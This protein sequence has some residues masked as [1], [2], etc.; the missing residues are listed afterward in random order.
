[1]PSKHHKANWITKER[2]L[3]I[4][5]RDNFSCLF[6]GSDLRRVDPFFITLDHLKCRAKHGAN[7]SFSDLVT[8]CRSCN[9]ARGSKEWYD[10]APGGAKP[11]IQKHRR[12]GMVRFVR[13][14]TALINGTA[15]GS[16]IAY[17]QKQ[18]RKT[19]KRK[20]VTVR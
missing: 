11:R 19:G 3:A 17:A 4:Y 10:Y 18:L 5:L 16:S 9:S 7:D 20:P 15:G 12:M 13:M 1:M 6:C 14:A 2:R 8:A